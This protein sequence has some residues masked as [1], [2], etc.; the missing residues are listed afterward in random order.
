MSYSTFYILI[1]LFFCFSTSSF[2]KINADE[3]KSASS[4]NFNNNKNDLTILKK[5][6]SLIDDIRRVHGDEKIHDLSDNDSKS[7]EKKDIDDNDS[8]SQYN[9]RN[10]SE[11]KLATFGFLHAFFAS[12]SVIVVSEIGDKTFFI[13]AIMAMKHS[14]STVIIIIII[15]D[16]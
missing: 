4:N 15:S 12:L 3:L 10:K 11:N 1:F 5:R 13:A 14:R 16:L 7:N 2:N 8:K 6:D 9:K